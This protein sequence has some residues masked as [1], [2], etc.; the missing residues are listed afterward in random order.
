MKRFV[1]YVS[2]TV[3]LSLYCALRTSAQPAGEAPHGAPPPAEKATT[4]MSSE[5]ADMVRDAVLQL[6]AMQEDGGQWPY[7]GV[8]RVNR[9]IPIG[10]RVGGTAIVAGTLLCA[11]TTDVE[12]VVAAIDRAT[13]FV[14]D[15]LDHPLMQPSTANAYDVRVWGHAYALEYFCMLRAAKRTGRH[16]EAI[17]NWIPRLVEI[18]IEEE[19]AGGGWNYANRR[20]HASFVTGPVVQAL[21]LARSQGEKVPQEVF[22]RAKEVLLKSRTEEGAF[23][24]SGIRGEDSRPNARAQLPGSI[25]RSAICESTLLLLGAGS[26]DAVRGSVSAFHAHWDE[27][28]KRRQKTGTHEGPYGIAPYYFYYGHR[29]VAQAIEM[30][31]E[32]ERPAER[33]RLLKVILRSRDSDG[34]WND[35]IFPRSKNYGTAMIVLALLGDKA[36]Q[37]VSID[38]QPD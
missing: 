30:L 12:P 23:L 7:E 25:A 13:A 8:Y 3:V 31:P 29:Y 24:Y 28:E 15:G 20:A 18:L 5:P 10:Y 22:D 34:S 38:T 9:E 26:T 2:C 4:A 6:V 14:V 36:P 11:A 19:I 21:L 17:T 1:Q 32:A 16:D 27:L 33:A 35:R 37:P